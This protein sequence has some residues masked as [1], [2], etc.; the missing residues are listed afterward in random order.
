[1][2]RRGP[3]HGGLPDYMRL[4]SRTTPSFHSRI[5]KH[6]HISEYPR[7]ANAWGFPIPGEQHPSATSVMAKDYFVTYILQ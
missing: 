1:M 3:E 6:V 7:P 2:G 4:P 5:G